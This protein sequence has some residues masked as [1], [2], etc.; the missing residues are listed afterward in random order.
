MKLR[1][2]LL[3]VAALLP[4]SFE[5]LAAQAGSQRD[6]GFAPC[7]K[8]R[9]GTTGRCSPATFLLTR[10]E[11]QGLPVALSV[12]DSL[13]RRDPEIRR[14]GHAYAHAIGIAAYTGAEEVS[15]VFNQCT[16]IFQSGCHHGVIQGYF[17]VHSQEQGTGVD[18]VAVNALCA[19]QRS[20]PML[21]WHLFQCVHGLG[22]G[23]MMVEA[24]HVPRALDGCDLLQDLWEREVCYSAVFMEN[25]VQATSS[26]A[27]LGRPESRSRDGAHASHGAGS[28]P[29]FPSLK[30]DDPLYPCTVLED[31]YLPACYQMQTSAIL[32]LNGFDVAEAAR[33]CPS[34]PER[35]RATCFQSLGRDISAIT[36]QDHTRAIEL[37]AHAP[38]DYEQFCHLGYA[39]NLVDVTANPADGFAFCRVV[40]DERSKRACYVGMGEEL[41]V[42]NRGRDEMAAAC[43]TAEG[44]YVAACRLGAGLDGPSGSPEPED[45]QPVNRGQ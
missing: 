11:A 28:H 27:T 10:L 39:K 40:K 32:Q 29:D 15:R 17:N 12:L 38:N 7:D 4:S 44:Q 9:S 23:L 5:I 20:D 42:L 33:I 14:L 21:R 2:V 8:V 13:S 25:V 31:Q 35:F 43:E 26:E 36:V 34:A 37:C 41:W 24:N 1:Y 45:R 18:A 30:A 19:A 16:P 3:V 22:H 6:V